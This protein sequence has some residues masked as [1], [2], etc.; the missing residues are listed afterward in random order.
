MKN[1]FLSARFEIS[2]QASGIGIL[3]FCAEHRKRS[4]ATDSGKF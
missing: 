2:K 1:Y 3:K 4:K